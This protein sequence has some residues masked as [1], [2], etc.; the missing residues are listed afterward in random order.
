MK[1]KVKTKEQL[2]DELAEMRQRVAELEAAETKGKRAEEALARRTRELALLNRAGQA[3][4]STLDLDQVLATVLEE[5]CRLLNVAAGSVWLTSPETGALVCQQAI[6]PQSE[7]VRG[8]R[9][10]PGEGVAGWVARHGESLI[11]PDT[12]TDERHFGGVDRRIGMETRSILSVPLP[13]TR[14]VIGVLQVV[15]TD[16]GSFGPT[17]VALIEPLA[18]SASIAI[19]NARLYQE[20]QAHTE[21][22]EQRVRERTA[23]LA[24]QHARLEAILY[25]VS[26]GIVVADAAG[27]ILHANPVAQT[28]LTQ[29]LSPEDT[30]RLRET[31]HSVA[32]RPGEQPVELL[33][34]TGLDLELS[35]APILEPVPG[36]P[37][38]EKPA[39]AVVAIHDVSHLKALDRMKTRF[40]TNISHELRTPITTIKLYAHLMRQ[41]PDKW[42]QHLD[43]LAQ[44]ADHQAQL[45]EGILEISRIDA[46]RLEME[47]R[48]TF[49]NE[50]TETTV[51]SHQVLAQEQG[52]TLEHHP[53]PAPSPSRGEGRGEGPIALVDPKR[54]MQVL[55]NLV[56]NAIRY[57]PEGGTVVVS[58]GTEEAEGRTW[59]TVTVADTGMGIPEDELPHIFD[60]FFRGVKPRSMQISGTGLGLALVK[61]IVELHGGHVTVE[62]PCKAEGAE[63][64]G[65]GEEGVGSTFTVWLPPSGYHPATRIALGTKR[66]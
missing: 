54:M 27:E 63:G 25:S 2:I 17:D 30:A 39:A 5:V 28:W 22:L 16:V 38:P 51:V 66:S 40:T 41:H 18:A 3:F 7:V 53:S 13:G 35:G 57:T 59:A 14:G 46:G 23:Q 44:E 12:Q 34:L 10:A 20:L 4:S 56:E 42:K 49:L 45:V 26:D 19:Q 8:W 36:E 61:E 31:V 47:P 21:H 15:D 50:L 62:S 29:T 65:A 64:L 37:V 55:N 43:T 33:E 24:A 60:R 58:T 32:T 48:P 52:L 6:G 9:L 11:V 1:D